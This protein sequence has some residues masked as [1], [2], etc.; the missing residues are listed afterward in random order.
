L[1]NNVITK[2]ILTFPQLSTQYELLS[3]PAGT[4]SVVPQFSEEK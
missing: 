1:R 4:S 3:N 2:R